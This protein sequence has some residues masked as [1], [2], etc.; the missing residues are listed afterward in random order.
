M[1]IV[2]LVKTESFK[3]IEDFCQ[4]FPVSKEITPGYWEKAL[5]CILE[6]I[7]KANDERTITLNDLR[8]ECYLKIK[9]GLIDLFLLDLLSLPMS[10]G[11]N[12]VLNIVRQVFSMIGQAIATIEEQEQNE[13]EEHRWY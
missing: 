5:N 2:E 13:K 7:N 10:E 11:L 8:K 4:E 3:S 1:A 6:K 12:Q 9:W